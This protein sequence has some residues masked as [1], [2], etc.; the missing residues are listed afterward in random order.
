LAGLTPA[1]YSKG[2]RAFTR[3]LCILSAAL[4]LGCMNSQDLDHEDPKAPGDVLGFYALSGGL[5]EDTCGAE[6]LSAPAKWSFEVRLS[7]DGSAFY[8]LNGREAIVGEIDK[9]GAF[10]FETHIDMPLAARHGAAK[11]CTVVRRDL[12][13]GTLAKSEDSLNVKL[14]YAYEA[15]AESDCS[16]FITGTAG[17]PE[18]LPCRMTYSLEGVRVSSE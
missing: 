12:A 8:W 17:M 3:A 6:S 15:T 7:R 5:S 14:S 4:A 11:G 1:G 9:A 18:A 13:K 10:D 2:M 16:E